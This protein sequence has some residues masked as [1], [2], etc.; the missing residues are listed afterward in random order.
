M[1]YIEMSLSAFMKTIITHPV[2]CNIRRFA[3][4]RDTPLKRGFKK[5]P[6]KRGDLG[7]C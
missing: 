7:V 2:P 6:L 4:T 1:C 5:S 3:I